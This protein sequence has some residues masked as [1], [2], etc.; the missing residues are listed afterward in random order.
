MNITYINNACFNYLFI[1][2][3]QIKTLKIMHQVYL[4]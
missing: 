3:S 1:I 2:M 4:T